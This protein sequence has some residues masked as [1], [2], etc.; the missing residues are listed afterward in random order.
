MKIRLWHF[1]PH[2]LIGAFYQA[3]AGWRLCFRNKVSFWRYLPSSI[4]C[5]TTA[6]NYSLTLEKEGMTPPCTILDI[7]ANVSQMASLLLLSSNKDVLIHSFEPNIAL[8]PMGTCHYLALS[9][10]DGEAEFQTP[11][12]E[13]MWGTI[14]GDSS[15]VSLHS[16]SVKVRMARM[17]S[18]VSHGE[19]NWSS[20]PHPI[21]VKVDTEGGEM[22]VLRG[23]GHL[24]KDVDYLIIEM[25][26]WEERGRHYALLEMCRFL[27]EAGFRHSKILYSCFEGAEAPSYCDFIFWRDAAVTT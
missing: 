4:P 19:L 11:G 26:N 9:D 15:G 25:G 12:G 27:E 17:D 18:L 16:S 22:A 13:T 20:L 14:H 21:L 10:S 3:V 1:L 24:V 5:M 6:W 2:R 7:G 8:R 23:F